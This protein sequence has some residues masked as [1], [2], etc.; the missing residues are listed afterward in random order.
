MYKY[1]LEDILSDP[2][3]V[4]YY[5]FLGADEVLMNMLL[6]YGY[7]HNKPY[8]RPYRRNSCDSGVQAKLVI[9]EV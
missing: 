5:E 7:K 8:S 2:F 1:K 9:N 6:S 3:T 4:N